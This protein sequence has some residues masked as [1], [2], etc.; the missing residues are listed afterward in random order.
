[1]PS[2]F[3]LSPGIPLDVGVRCVSFDGD[4]DRVIYFY[5][6]ENQGFHLLDGD[7]IATL[8]RRLFG[9]GNPGQSATAT[10]TL[11]YRWQAI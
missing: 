10:F 6:D 1:M 8:V 9:L 4:A 5:H 11:D 3:I 2:F 7:K